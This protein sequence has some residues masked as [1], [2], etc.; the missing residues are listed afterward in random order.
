MQK[1]TEIILFTYDYPFGKSEKTFIE[2][3]LSQLSKDF[4]KIEIINQKNSKNKILDSCKDFNK[5]K[6]P[7]VA[8]Y[9]G[10]YCKLDF[11]FLKCR[12]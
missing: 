10:D 11:C 2:Y 4:D 8:L 5:I 3:E 6:I 9:F 7:I 12:S 1:N